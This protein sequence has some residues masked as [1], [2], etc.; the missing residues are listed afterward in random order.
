MWP[1]PRLKHEQ[2]HI[3]LGTEQV[4]CNWITKESGSYPAT[5]KAHVRYD[6]PLTSQTTLFNPTLLKTYLYDF[7]LRHEL[8]NAFA[9][10][11][12]QQ[13]LVNECI[14]PHNKSNAQ[15]DDLI[16]ER[17]WHTRYTSGYLGSDDQQF[18]YYVCTIAEQ[19]LCQLQV[20]CTQLPL[21]V[22]RISSP[23]NIQLQ[24]LHQLLGKAFVHTR[25]VGA[26]DTSHACIPSVFSLELIRR[27]LQI[28]RPIHINDTDILYALGSYLGSYDE[29]D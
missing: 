16:D 29:N 15:L 10:I 7:L 1:L 17:L 25:I 19:L 13:P 4:S 18:L 2:I 11:V 6:G 5:L 28:S 12:L 24:L 20:V 26:L 9:Y 21:H 8:E 27:C 22:V 3:I 23:L 14:I